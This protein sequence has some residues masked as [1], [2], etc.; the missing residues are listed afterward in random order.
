MPPI[1]HRSFRG[2]YRS[3]PPAATPRHHV[4]DPG[5]S[6]TLAARCPPQSWPVRQRRCR[7]SPNNRSARR[8]PR[9]PP[10]LASRSTAGSTVQHAPAAP[11][12]RLARQPRRAPPRFPEA[13]ACAIRP[14]SRSRSPRGPSGRPR[15]RAGAAM[16]RRPARSPRRGTAP[17]PAT[18]ARSATHSRAPLERCMPRRWEGIASRCPPPCPCPARRACSRGGPKSRPRPGRST[19]RPLPI[20]RLRP[21]GRGRFFPTTPRASPPHQA[22]ARRRSLARPTPSEAPG[23]PRPSCSRSPRPSPT[24]HACLTPFGGCP[25]C[26]SRRHHTT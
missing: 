19:D 18:P 16:R 5:S 21:R 2:R 11:T 22:S 12:G 14:P 26:R 9:R 20:V 7:T 8:T 1:W 3:L 6:R 25:R 23:S 15:R 13:S 4:R 24:T 10:S 17:G